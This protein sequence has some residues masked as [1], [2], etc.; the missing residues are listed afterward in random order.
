MPKNLKDWN[1]KSVVMK[2]VQIN[3]AAAK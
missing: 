2:T 3:A 1:N